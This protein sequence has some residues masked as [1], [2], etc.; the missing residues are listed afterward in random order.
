MNI[1]KI[2]SNGNEIAIVNSD[3]FNHPPDKRLVIF[4]QGGG[5]PMSAMRFFC[6]C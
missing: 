3:F 1:K 5:L 4:G 2:I 6:L